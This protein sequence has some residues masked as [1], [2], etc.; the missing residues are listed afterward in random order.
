MKGQKKERIK[1]RKDGGRS[2]IFE[3][4]REKRKN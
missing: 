4:A 1:V 3:C 2:D